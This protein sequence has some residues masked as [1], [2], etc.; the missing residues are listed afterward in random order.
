MRSTS[1]QL[2]AQA[3]SRNLARNEIHLFKDSYLGL[4]HRC[5][6]VELSPNK[7]TLPLSRLGSVLYLFHNLLTHASTRETTNNPNS[8]YVCEFRAVEPHMC[9]SLRAFSKNG[10]LTL[11]SLDVC[12][13]GI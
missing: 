8:V 9:N 6:H 12:D 2:K 7:V 5:L 3:L 4:D 13:F 1:Y 10:T 11:V